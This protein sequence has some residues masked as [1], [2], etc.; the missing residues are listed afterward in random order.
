M[1]SSLT[2]SGMMLR[3]VPVDVA[4]DDDGVTGIFFAAD[5]GL[6]LGDEEG[7]DDD[8]VAAYEGMGRLRGPRCRG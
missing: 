7:G 5:D 2:S 8:G 6:N 3:L 4:D 1:S